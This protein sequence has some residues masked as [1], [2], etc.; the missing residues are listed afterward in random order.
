MFQVFEIFCVWSIFT[1]LKGKIEY[2]YVR[3]INCT[4]DTIN[5]FTKDNVCI[6]SLVLKPNCIFVLHKYPEILIWGIVRS[7]FDHMFPP[8]ELNF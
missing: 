2:M 8:T 7:E 4:K 6:L 3:S 5:T 1:E